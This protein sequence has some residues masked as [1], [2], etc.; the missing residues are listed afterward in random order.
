MNSSDIDSILAFLHAAEKL[1]TTHR[2]G[3][4]STGNPES[5][6]E[7]TWRLC[8]MAMLLAPEIPEVDVARLLRICLV[9]DLGEAVGGDVP[10]P[11]QARRAAA[12]EPSK[13]AQE[14]RDLVA[15]AALLPASRRDEIVALWDEYAAG[16]TREAQL[17]KALDKLETILQHTQGANPPDFDHE[18]NLRY[19]RQFT[20]HPPLVAAIRAILDQET[21]RL[22]KLS[23]STSRT[24]KG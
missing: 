16:A 14:R 10:A 1:K 5:V 11:E 20:E 8:L 22:A 12:G 4:T 13:D 6:A 15:L 9:H 24:C 19:G 23:S 17:A 18:F 3:Y 2:S 21:E 7:H